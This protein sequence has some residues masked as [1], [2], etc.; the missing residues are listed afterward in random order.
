MK[1]GGRFTSRFGGKQ[2]MTRELSCGGR[3]L[4]LN[5]RA[6]CRSTRAVPPDSPG[7]RHGI[8]S[9]RS[10]GA[11]RDWSA[12]LGAATMTIVYI[13]ASGLLLSAAARLTNPV[14][15]P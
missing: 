2:A 11:G 3:L 10:S 6:D 14:P 5:F 4:R 9:T 15:E 13:I 1:G 7:H 8:D 12:I